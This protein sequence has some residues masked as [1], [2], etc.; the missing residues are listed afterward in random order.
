MDFKDA[1]VLWRGLGIDYEGGVLDHPARVAIH[2]T[3]RLWGV[4]TAIVLGFVAWRAIRTG[5]SRAVRTAGI[6]LAVLLAVQ[7]TIGPVMV[8]KALPLELA[9][10]HNGVAA[11]L[12]LAVVAL[13][14]FLWT[15][16]T[17]R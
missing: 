9:T 13:L 12:V 15:P 8:L 1:F 16:R 6:A 14:R 2:F 17:L 3:H 11:L 7:W 4:V 5:Q 10:A